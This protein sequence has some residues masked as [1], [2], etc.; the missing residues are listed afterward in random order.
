MAR[1]PELRPCPPLPVLQLLRHADDG[2]WLGPLRPWI[3][4]CRRGLDPQEAWQQLQARSS[5]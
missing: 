3:E 2:D 4:L 5:T 1:S